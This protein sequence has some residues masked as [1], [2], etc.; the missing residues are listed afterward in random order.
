MS[1]V[2]LT[3]MADAENPCK[4]RGEIRLN[5]SY[6]A[7]SRA[8]EEM[9]RIHSFDKGEMLKIDMWD[10]RKRQPPAHLH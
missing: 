3:L 6:N 7:T 10:N 1:R 2:D 8:A 5:D 9:L 4:T